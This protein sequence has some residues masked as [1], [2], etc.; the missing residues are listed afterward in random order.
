MPRQGLEAPNWCREI[1]LIL[2]S[3]QAW[4]GDTSQ[5]WVPLR[6]NAGSCE[7][8]SAT[9]EKGSHAFAIG[10]IARRARGLGAFCQLAWHLASGSNFHLL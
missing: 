2:R 9:W 4:R 3:D 5:C 1:K 7:I 6:P 10:D 8:L